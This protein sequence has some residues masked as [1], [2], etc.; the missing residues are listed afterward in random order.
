MKDI[1][2]HAGAV[3]TQLYGTAVAISDGYHDWNTY[4]DLLDITVGLVPDRKR[5]S[6]STSTAQLIFGGADRTK[7]VGSFIL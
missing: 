1:P 4:N 6:S 3:L 5:A 7:Y 2:A